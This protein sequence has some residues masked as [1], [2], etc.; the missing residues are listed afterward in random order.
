MSRCGTPPQILNMDES[1]MTA[2]PFNGKN[3]GFLTGPPLAPR[4]RDTHHVSD[5]SLFGTLLLGLKSRPP[6][7]L[8]AEV[9]KQIE[10]RA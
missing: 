10:S 1:G 9:R 5:V 2:R 6:F 8:M 3:I 4:F 7:L